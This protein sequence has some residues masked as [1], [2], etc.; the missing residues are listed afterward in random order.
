MGAVGPWSRRQP[1]IRKTPSLS[2]CSSSTYSK[3][4]PSAAFSFVAPEMADPKSISMA[5]GRHAHKFDEA[6]SRYSEACDAQSRN[7]P[8][9]EYP[10][11]SK[12]RSRRAMKDASTRCASLNLAKVGF[13]V[14]TVAA[15]QI[16]SIGQR[17]NQRNVMPHRT[18]VRPR[19]S[20]SADGRQLRLWQAALIPVAAFL[21]IRCGTIPVRRNRR[22]LGCGTGYCAGHAGIAVE[23]NNL[24][25]RRYAN[26][27]AGHIA[28]LSFL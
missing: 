11:K 8:C 21:E 14:R 9:E 26:S 20:Y 3:A 19:L 16:S 13:N 7:G 1:W 28:W 4:A 22:E 23:I 18:C 17:W 5:L 2:R 27:I 12:P 24:S 25:N 10:R 6:V 15:H